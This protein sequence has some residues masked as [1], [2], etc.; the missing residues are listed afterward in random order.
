[1]VTVG[2]VLTSPESGWIRYDDINNNISYG[3]TGWSSGT[4]NEWYNQTYHQNNTIN[5]TIKFNFTKTKIRIIATMI[6][7]GSSNIRIK[8]DNLE[9]TFSL[10]SLTR[11]DQALVYEKTGLDEKEHCAEITLQNTGY[12]FLDAID[13]DTLGTLKPYSVLN[14]F[15]VKQNSNYYTIKSTNYDSI[16]THNFTPLTLT[17]GLT[18]NKSDI[19]NFGFSDLSIL[20]NNMTVNGDTFI[21]VSKFDN[22]TELKLY[23]G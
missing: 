16:T 14:K 10:Y 6:N 19:E 15:L 5:S 8:I 9:E 7:S 22:T 20:T 12:L 2:Q 18:P 17:G 1:M 21:P 11:L 3:G 4:S 13:I 23:K